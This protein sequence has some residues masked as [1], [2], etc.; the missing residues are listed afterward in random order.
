MSHISEKIK[1][2]ACAALFAGFSA[3]QKQ[4]IA[5]I[6]NT[7]IEATFSSIQQS[8]LTP[9]CA[10][11]G[12]HVGNNPAGGLNLQAGQ[13]FGNLVN[14]QSREDGRKFLVQ[15]NDAA[16]SYLFMKI[17]GSGIVGARMPI[18]GSLSQSQINAVRDWIDGGAQDN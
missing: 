17:I 9:T 16:N 8:V 1:I 12:C 15:P 3:C 18:G 2:V 10:R 11:S 6:D 13:A 5:G 7:Q 14:V 4:P